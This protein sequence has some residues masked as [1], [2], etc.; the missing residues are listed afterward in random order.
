YIDIDQCTED[1]NDTKE[2]F[3]RKKFKRNYIYL[4]VT[5]QHLIKT[6]N[7]E[8]LKYFMS[9]IDLRNLNLSEKILHNIRRIFHIKIV[10]YNRKNFIDML[11]KEFKLEFNYDFMIK[12]SLLSNN[13]CMLEYFIDKGL[14]IQTALDEYNEKV[15]THIKENTKY[16]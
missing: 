10:F 12:E 7:I 2:D 13:M 3:T 16:S 6:N 11:E 14:D 4:S 8:M 9:M 15:L 1:I 5:I